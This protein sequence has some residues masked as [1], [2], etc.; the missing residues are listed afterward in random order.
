MS[1][2]TLTENQER[3]MVPGL[4]RGL[5]LL[6]EF[7]RHDRTLTAPE[8]ARRLQ[9]PR[10]TIFRLLAT[11]E[12]LGFV[13]RSGN[14]Y[15]L[16]MAVLRLGFEYLAS[17]ELTEL[18]Q[19]ILRRLCDAIGYSCNL[20]VRDGRNIVYVAKISPPSIL[21]SAVNVGTRLPAHATVL[22]RIL[23]EDLDLA[24][25]RELYPEKQL[26][27]FSEGTPR[28]TEEL[29]DLVQNDRLRGYALSEGFFEASISTVAAPVR[30]H[31]GRV[32]AA[33]G[34]TIPA[35]RIAEHLLE[36]LVRQVRNSAEELSGLLGHMPNPNVLS[37]QRVH[38]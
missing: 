36:P 19:P 3:Y 1:T 31:T 23:L 27:R 34:V 38:S 12:A 24:A 17:L 13:T 33:M 37:L 28:N 22:G 7:T 30:D 21:T 25:L 5:T 9:L 11:L 15:R 4:E 16:G 14:E 6:G 18:G 32:C 10:T 29:F 2:D 20:V 35:T 26:E 8:L